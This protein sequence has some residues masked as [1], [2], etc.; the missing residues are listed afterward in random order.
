M[1]DPNAPLQNVGLNAYQMCE[2]L[3]ITAQNNIKL[4]PQQKQFLAQFLPEQDSETAKQQL[5]Y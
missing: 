3:A 1:Q 2:L 4:T 5:Y